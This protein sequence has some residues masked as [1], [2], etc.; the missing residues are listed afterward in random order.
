MVFCVF[1]DHIRLCQFHGLVRKTSVSHS[2][3]AAEMIS[4][5][6]G[7][8]MEGI[9]AMKSWDTVIDFL[10]SP[11]LEATPSLLHQTQ[12]LTHQ[13]P[14][15]NIDCVPP[16]AR[17][18]G[19]RTSFFIFED[20]EA[21]IN[22]STKAESHNAS[23]MTHTSC[24]FGSILQHNTAIGRHSHRK[25]ILKRHMDTIDTIGEQHDS[26]HIYSKKFVSFLCSYESFHFQ[27][28]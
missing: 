20:N 3:T 16:N 18:F 1:W 6:A 5:D 25:I 2:N 12:I 8:R 4:F 11:K 27:H 17:L 7:L 14:P 28:E 19:V 26:H 9:P 24:R 13:E 22:K 10:H 15:G 21:V 23:W